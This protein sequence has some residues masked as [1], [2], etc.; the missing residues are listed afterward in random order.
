MPRR[1]NPFQQLVTLLER[2]LQPEGATVHHSKEL[3][4][5]I[6]RRRREVDIVV[7][8]K[9]GPH[10]L[11]VGIECTATA[12]PATVEWVECMYGKHLTLTDKLILVAKA[13][14]TADA[15]KKANW[16]R[17]GAYTLAE[18]ESAPWA[19]DLRG[20]QQINFVAFVVPHV[21]SVVVILQQSP[22]LL[23]APADLDLERAR[24][25]NANGE[26]IG[27]VHEV[28]ERVMR[29]P[30]VLKTL[31]ERAFTDADTAVD[32]EYPMRN[33]MKL[34]DPSGREFDIAALRGEA[35]CR[36][37]VATVPFTQGTYAE[38]AIAY[39][40]T[41]MLEHSIRVVAAHPKCGE[42]KLGVSLSRPRGS[43]EPPLS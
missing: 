28:V 23:E 43:S 17:I 36:K 32:F 27:I 2:V 6:T 4:D 3:E 9:S 29:N 22:D 39:A 20:L 5:R 31:E 16:L 30:A 37:H 41:N 35:R 7:E 11:L 38:T 34:I 15:K 8:L 25:R 10:S 21:T 42:M 19:S 18:M 40:E 14:F 24:I 26:D 13:G 1:T 12:R 33:G